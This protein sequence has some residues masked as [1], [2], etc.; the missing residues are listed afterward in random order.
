MNKDLL[1][2]CML[3]V[4]LLCQ[5]S[6]ISAK[7]LDSTRLMSKVYRAY[8]LQNTDPDSALLLSNEVLKTSILHKYQEGIAYAYIR[9]GSI[10][11]LQGKNDSALYLINES[12]SIRENISDIQGAIG[13]CYLLSYI[14]EETGNLDSAYAVLYHAKSL[15]EKLADSVN[16]IDINVEL[17]NLYILY[18]EV[19]TANNLYRESLGLSNR[20][21]YNDGIIQCLSGLGRC[22]Y[23]LDE[24]DTAIYYFNKATNYYLQSDDRIA[25]ATNFQNLALC[26]VGLRDYV[27]ANKYYESSLNLFDSLE[28]RTEQ[29]LVLY[30]MG[31]M[32]LNMESYDSAI[33]FLKKSKILSELNNDI[34]RETLCAEFLSLAY[35]LKGN[36]EIAYEYQENF[37][38]LNDSLL[39]EEKVRSISEMQTK[40]ETQLKEQEIELLDEENKTKTAQR[41]ALFV[42][43][44]LLILSASALIFFFVQKNK[45]SK[46][47][48]QIAEQKLDSVLDE[49][50]INTYNAMLKGQEE[51]RLRIAND[52]HDR[53]GSMLSTIKLMFS[54][55]EDKI[56]QVLEENKTQM[57]KTTSLIDDACVEVRRISHNLGAGLIANYGLVNSLEDLTETINQTSKVDCKLL[58]YNM[59][60]G[61]PLRFEVELY[62]IAQEIL[63][64][65]LKYANAKSITVQL[66]RLDEEFSMTIEDDGVGFDFARAKKKGGMGLANIEKRAAKLNGKVYIDTAINKGC[67]SIIEIPLKQS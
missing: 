29:A 36:Y 4:V 32:Y 6:P 56:G 31:T 35:K 51:E 19:Q 53:L 25:L 67:I 66:S 18:D 61:L 40:Y 23:N 7:E 5:I 21:G 22:A 12:K 37:I 64:N 27:K 57:D 20:I 39:N 42:G 59:E 33:Y 16:E 48:K 26:Y 34:H 44:L 62:R 65:A 43:I 10:Y 38:E 46:Q 47:A 17:A 49:Q 45:I 14:Y 9:I 50:E 1:I 54:S 63:N 60:E 24:L 8:E 11:N 13:S 58:V 52:L 41:N 28:F 3:F 55:L 30:N 2:K 15:N